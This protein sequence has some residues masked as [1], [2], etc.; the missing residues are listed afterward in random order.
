MK[1]SKNLQ[2]E[3]SVKVK[4]LVK[5]LKE[6]SIRKNM[7]KIENIKIMT[8]NYGK[9]DTFNV[10]A[11]VKYFDAYKKEVALT[12]TFNLNLKRKTLTNTSHAFYYLTSIENKINKSLNEYKVYISYFLRSKSNNIKKFYLTK[13]NKNTFFIDLSN[14]NQTKKYNFLISN[15]LDNCY[16]G[17]YKPNNASMLFEG[18]HNFIK[19]KDNCKNKE[20]YNTLGF[21]DKSNI[22]ENPLIKGLTNI[23]NMNNNEKQF[24]KLI[25]NSIYKYF[26]IRIKS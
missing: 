2:L 17:K 26:K 4:E 16:L 1:I 18:I 20:L 7:T 9:E 8:I 15:Y 19:S 21:N 24:V 5:V 3:K 23:D 6:V 12:D 13:D 25:N 14:K 22:L 11:N 10:E